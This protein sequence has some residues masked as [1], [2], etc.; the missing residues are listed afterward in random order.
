MS[1]GNNKTGVKSVFLKFYYCCFIAQ[2]FLFSKIRILLPVIFNAL[3]Q[4]CSPFWNLDHWLWWW[5][6]LKSV[7][8][9]YHLRPLYLYERIF[10][11][12][13]YP[14]VLTHESCS[15]SLEVRRRMELTRSV[16]GGLEEN[17]W[18]TRIALRTQLRLYDTYV[19][20]VFLYGSEH[21]RRANKGE[22]MPLAR[23]VFGV[24][25]TSDGRIPSPTWNFREE[26]VRTLQ[27][28]SIAW[29]TLPGCLK[30][31]TPVVSWSQ[32]CRVIGGRDLHGW[33]LGGQIWISLTTHWKESS[34]LQR[35]GP[36]G[37]RWSM[38]LLKV[39]RSLCRSKLLKNRSILS[40]SVHC[41]F[42]SA[43]QPILTERMLCEIRVPEDL[44]ILFQQ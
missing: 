26:P 2:E 9:R 44:T 15:N 14:V 10:S 39:Q 11:A 34:P 18:H 30:V 8:Q 27:S 7:P 33:E 21:W 40:C 12:S 4:P 3:Q 6:I 17:I 35:T 41:G 16:F 36:C 1:D 31:P 37:D 23:N 22:L 13:W 28:L 24:Y 29:V 42:G 19:V 38:T 32:M 5:K 43:K 20:P 25:A